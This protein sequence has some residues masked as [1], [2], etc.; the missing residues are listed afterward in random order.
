[1][2]RADRIA[3]RL[4]KITENNPLNFI[5]QVVQK[6]VEDQDKECVYEH[7]V[8]VGKLQKS[9]YKYENEVLTLA[10]TGPEY[11]Q[12]KTTTRLV[13]DVVHWL[14]EVL[15]SAMVDAA[16]VR[17][18]FRERKFSFQKGRASEMLT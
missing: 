13:C 8:A 5:R 17:T 2:E 9:M 18:M 4:Q 1:M 10:G 6:F 7:I 14:E 12:I 15:C 11:E 3:T 16:E